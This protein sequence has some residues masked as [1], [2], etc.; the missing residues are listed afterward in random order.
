MPGAIA[1]AVSSL[2]SAST[3]RKVHE[4]SMDEQISRLNTHLKEETKIHNKIE[5]AMSDGE[6]VKL[7]QDLRSLWE[8]SARRVRRCYE[9]AEAHASVTQR[10]TTLISYWRSKILD[11]FPTVLL[12]VTSQTIPRL[13]IDTKIKH[14]ST[15][16]L[17]P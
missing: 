16:R 4:R 7:Q 5:K 14:G 6:K 1:D 15:A 17:Q 10:R 11:I 3:P 12:P 9:K 8:R 13:R 2:P